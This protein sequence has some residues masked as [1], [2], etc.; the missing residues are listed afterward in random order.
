M[1]APRDALFDKLDRDLDRFA[2]YG[3][4]DPVADDEIE[5]VIDE[6]EADYALADRYETFGETYVA[7]QLIFRVFERKGV[8]L[9]HDEEWVGADRGLVELAE[10]AD[11]DEEDRE[12]LSDVEANAERWAPED[13]D[14]LLAD[15]VALTDGLLDDL[16]WDVEGDRRADDTVQ[17]GCERDGHQFETELDAEGSEI[18]VDGLI[19]LLNRVVAETT[20]DDRRFAL[21]P[22]W[23]STN[24][25]VFFVDD[26]GT[27][28]NYFSFARGSLQRKA[29]E[30]D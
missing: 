12:V 4:I 17:V 20:D 10:R 9:R 3:E 2:M 1:T 21:I 14:E 24:A 13:Y 19:E 28:E 6:H 7:A 23:M 16:S 8:A 27:F 26:V 5:T 25:H 15:Y 18:D 11:I 22:T 30:E 29:R